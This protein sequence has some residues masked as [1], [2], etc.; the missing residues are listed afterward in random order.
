MARRSFSKTRVKARPITFFIVA[1]IILLG[2]LL[3]M[4]GLNI[5]V[6]GQSGYMELYGASKI[7]F[8]I[9]I[10]GGVEAVFAPKDFSGTP[11][12]EDLASAR[13]VIELRMDNL[14]ILDR[15]ITTDK[16]NGRIIIR[17]PW[18]S[19]ETDFNPEQALKELGTMAKLTFQ[20]P[21]GTIV[22]DGTN[23][24]S[25]TA[26]FDPNTND[27]IV[28]LEMDAKGATAFAEATG[29]LV[30]TNGE[31]SIYMDQT[32]I[33]SPRVI[34]KITDGKAM[35]TNIGTSEEALA[36]AQKINAGALPFAL[37]AISSSSISPSLGSGAL[38]VMTLAGLVAL[39]LICLFMLLYYRLPGFVAIFSLVG[40]MVGILL[41]ISIPQQ[42]LTLQGIAGIILSIGMGVDANIIIAERIKEEL[43][44]GSSL[45]TALANGFH[46]A[47]SA[48]MD[49]NVTVAIAAVV[50]MIF[51]SG[52]MLSFGY[53]LFVGVVLNGLTGVIANRLMIGSLSQFRPLQNPRLYG[54]K[55]V[56]ADA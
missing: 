49:G 11:S 5:P 17:Y 44:A 55:K 46:K 51:G 21:D 33:S 13:S 27:P 30:A 6:P 4:F 40:Q 52:S 42:T 26:A 38:K 16:S 29:E 39:A 14:N 34:N 43:N 45:T 56:I 54:R 22:L 3:S 2:T 28:S 31:I 41:A 1:A 37:E 32:L 8:G 53:S 25:A 10:R 48:V 19:T 18:K 7:R 24:T 15:E 23:I 20:K 36:L 35:I 47:F 12:E 50:L 9:D